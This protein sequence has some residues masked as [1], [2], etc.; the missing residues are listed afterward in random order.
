MA[1]DIDLEIAE[2]IVEDLADESSLDMAE[3]LGVDMTFEAVEDLLESVGLDALGEVGEDTELEGAD[4]IPGLLVEMIDKL[5]K[6]SR[7][8]LGSFPVAAVTSGSAI[9]SVPPVTSSTFIDSLAQETEESWTQS[10]VMTDLEIVEEIAEDLVD[11][12]TLDMAEGLG[13]DI[14]FEAVEDLLESVGLDALWEVDEDTEL[15]GAD[16]VPAGLLFEM[17]DKLVEFSREALSSFSAVA[18]TPGSAISF[19]PTVTSS[20]FID[21][22]ARATEESWT[23][24]PVMT[25]SVDASAICKISL[26]LASVT[27]K[28]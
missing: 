7:E 8:L 1:E 4:L 17:I 3:D 10:P 25:D 28:H 14:S 5:V 19:V 12:S 21:S 24:S 26:I 23:Q 27:L 15:E 22:L 20:I 16:F 9:S 11:D 18:A 13:V 2:E 6:F